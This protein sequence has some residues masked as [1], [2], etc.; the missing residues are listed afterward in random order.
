MVNFIF[1]LYFL[2]I[3]IRARE[4]YLCIFLSL[5]KDDSKRPKYKDLLRLPFV[6]RQ[7]QERVQIND[8]VAS[9]IDR[10]SDSHA[11]M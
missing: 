9:V 5:T 10:M 7:Q 6:I 11:T 3:G 2:K 1:L 4:S 8:Y